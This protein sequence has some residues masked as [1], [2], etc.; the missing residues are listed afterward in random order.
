M[1]M[2]KFI[3]FAGFVCTTGVGYSQKVTAKTKTPVNKSLLKNSRDSLSYAIGASIGKNMEQQGLA[4]IDFSLL[5]RGMEDVF[6]KRMR[7]MDENSIN[8]SIQNQLKAYAEKKLQAEK[9]KGNAFLA[10]NKKRPGVITLESGLQYEVISASKDSV[11]QM[12]LAE[13][14]VVVNYIGT[15]V[16]GKEFDNSYKRNQPANF[17]VNRV[18]KG[19]T[20]ILQLMPVGSKWKVFIPSDLAYGD[21]GAG[22]GSIPGG[23]ALIFEISLEGIKP[24]S[25]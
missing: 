18:I 5:K 24:T 8:M 10:T 17:A 22:G 2:K 13:D 7:L 20:E 9:D 25:K 11:K 19:W 16:D 1:S 4:D 15:L 12:P 21:H 3:L 6:K 14:T 23:A